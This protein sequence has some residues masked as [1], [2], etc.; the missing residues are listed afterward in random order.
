MEISSEWLAFGFFE[1]QNNLIRYGQFL[2]ASLYYFWTLSFNLIPAGLSINKIYKTF[3]KTL[4]FK[5]L[6]SKIL[7][8]RHNLPFRVSN[9]HQISENSIN[10]ASS[11]MESTFVTKYTYISYLCIISLFYYLKWVNSQTHSYATVNV[12]RLQLAGEYFLLLFKK[13]DVWNECCWLYVIMQS[14]SWE[15]AHEL[16][17]LWDCSHDMR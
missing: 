4:D 10:F 11:T 16:F 3:T 1:M 9:S 14:E 5:I 7:N 2:M 12:C 8:F 13:R 6:G 15:C 17:I